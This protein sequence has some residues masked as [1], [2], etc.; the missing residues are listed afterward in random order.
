MRALGGVFNH[1]KPCPNR[2]SATITLMYVGSGISRTSY[3]PLRPYCS[4]STCNACMGIRRDMVSPVLVVGRV[5][6]V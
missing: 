5:V 6:C 2:V 3:Q 1:E 4:V